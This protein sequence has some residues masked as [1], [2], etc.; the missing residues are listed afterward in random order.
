[1]IPLILK[2]IDTEDSCHRHDKRSNLYYWSYL[3]CRVELELPCGFPIR[4]HPILPLVMHGYFHNVWPQEP[5]RGEKI[6]TN[7]SPSVYIGSPVFGE[8]DHVEALNHLMES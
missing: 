5:Y 3:L 7:L 2:L 6:P 4:F 8:L 1:M